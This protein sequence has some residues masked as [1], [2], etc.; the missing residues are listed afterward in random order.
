M[1]CLYVDYE[2]KSKWEFAVYL[3]SEVFKVVVK[4]YS[5]I[6]KPTL[7]DNLDCAFM[8]DNEAVYEICQRN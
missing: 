4:P 3:S 5:S 7:L 1:E 6:L 2:K 8:V